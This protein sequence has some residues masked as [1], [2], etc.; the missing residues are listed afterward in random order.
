MKI[1][2]TVCSAAGHKII[3]RNAF[4]EKRTSTG[5]DTIAIRVL[6]EKGPIILYINRHPR[7]GPFL[8][9]TSATTHIGNK[10]ER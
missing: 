1:L 2:A 10:L 3:I 5:T 9:E 4:S 6:I 8:S 7:H